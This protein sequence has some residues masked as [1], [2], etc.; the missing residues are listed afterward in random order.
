MW[1]G[2]AAS[3]LSPTGQMA[4]VKMRVIFKKLYDT[5]SI[6]LRVMLHSALNKLSVNSKSKS[7]TLIVLSMNFNLV[8]SVLGR[9]VYHL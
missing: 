7:I 9:F 1:I 6:R 2:V 4:D 3:D 8:I 5:E